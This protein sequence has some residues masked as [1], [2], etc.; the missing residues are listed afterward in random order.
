MIRID[1]HG[2]FG[3]EVEVQFCVECDSDFTDFLH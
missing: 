2:D 1:S 3:V